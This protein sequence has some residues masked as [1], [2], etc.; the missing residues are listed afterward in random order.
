MANSSI[1]AAFERMWEHAISKFNHCASVE[2]LDNHIE[3]KNNPHEVTA[4]QIGALPI[5]GGSME[6]TLT[7]NGIVLT[8]GVDYGTDDP[9][10]GVLGQLYFKKVT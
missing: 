6:N 5:A 1:Y 8:E 9:A 10:G 7:L 3:D 4:E 2:A